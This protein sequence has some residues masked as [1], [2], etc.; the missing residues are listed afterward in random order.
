MTQVHTQDH[1]PDALVA[2]AL[3]GDEDAFAALVDRYRPA[4]HAHCRRLLRSPHDAEDALQETLLRAWRRRD[5]FEGRSSFSWWLQR[6]ATNACMDIGRRRARPGWE[7]G[8]VDAAELAPADGSEADPAARITSRE[9]VE[10]AYLVALRTLPSR[11]RAVLV[12]REVLRFSAADT[13]AMLG[14]S[15]PSV[16]SALQR[17]RTTLRRL[18]TRAPTP[19]PS[20]SPAERELVRRLVEAHDRVDP[21]ALAALLGRPDRSLPS[22]P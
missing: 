22:R 20:A 1:R 21:V 7:V 9:A 16:N 17:A 15:V 14:G 6:I 11:Q 12:L 3:A 18:E 13:A 2:D 5:G 4:V 10:G 8:P 19:E